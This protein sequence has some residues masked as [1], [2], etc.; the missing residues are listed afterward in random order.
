MEVV[1][2]PADVRLAVLTQG[3]KA[4]FCAVKELL[5]GLR[6]YVIVDP[7]APVVVNE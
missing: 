5:L 7:R 3:P 2:V 6:V 4:L 1:F